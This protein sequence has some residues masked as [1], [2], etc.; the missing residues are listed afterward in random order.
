MVLAHEAEK[1]AHVEAAQFGRADR[2]AVAAREQ[3]GDSLLFEFVDH[4]LLL[5]LKGFGGG[6]SELSFDLEIGGVDEAPI[7]EQ[8]DV[9]NFVLQFTHV[10]GPAVR[11]HLLDRVWSEPRWR[12]G[13]SIASRR[14]GAGGLQDWDRGQGQSSAGVPA[15]EFGRRPA[16]RFLS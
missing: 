5:R 10:A 14:P 7:R 15:C 9:L 1:G 8:D 3:L 16:A 11:H 4:F 2:V 13:V 6:I 12:T